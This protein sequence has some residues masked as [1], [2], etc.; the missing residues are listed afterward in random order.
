[1]KA[2]IS[3]SRDDVDAMRLTTPRRRSGWR[4]T[5]PSN[6]VI[7]S[8]AVATAPARV[9]AVGA[10]VGRLGVGRLLSLA[11][12]AVSAGRGVDSG[13][14]MREPIAM[15]I[16]SNASAAATQARIRL[17]PRFSAGTDRMVTAR[18]V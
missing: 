15:P 11:T 8:A 13:E 3:R 17:D 6:A 10:D 4:R 12:E 9:R 2:S 16:A 1:M 7:E 18:P 14:A 5:S